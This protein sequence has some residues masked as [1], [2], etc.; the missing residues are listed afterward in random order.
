MATA[1]FIKPIDLKRNSII[2]GSVDVDSFIG[3][4][5]IAQEIHIRNYLGTDLY[6]K[7]SKLKSIYPIRLE[8]TY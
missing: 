5:K 3:Y 7:I 1:L 2:D 8:A 6:N 4:I